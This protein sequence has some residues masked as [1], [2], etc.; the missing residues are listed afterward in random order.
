[1]PAVPLTLT[2]DQLAKVMAAARELPPRSRSAFLQAVA[3]N[4]QGYKVTSDEDV[5]RAVR[6]A[7]L[8]MV[9]QGRDT[10]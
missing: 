4:L 1:M 7:L 10:G 9:A 6:H 8:A 2:D 5:D 3:G